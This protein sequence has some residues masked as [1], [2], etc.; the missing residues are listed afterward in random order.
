MDLAYAVSQATTQQAVRNATPTLAVSECFP[1][2]F[3]NPA[4]SA[5]IQQI[6]DELTQTEP[7]AFIESGHAWYSEG[8][9]QIDFLKSIA[10]D[11]HETGAAAPNREAAA[12]SKIVLRELSDR[13]FQPSRIDP[14][15]AGGI[16]ISF[17]GN[18]RYADIECL[19]SGNIVA[20]TMESDDNPKVW[21]PTIRDISAV[22]ADINGFICG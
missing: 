9:Q 1:G 19:N 7:V 6:V 18:G 4:A 8:L 12:V 5:Q 10:D 15:S 20:L 11:W 2:E 22:V 17:E 21:G 3:F 16:C 14:S 13:N